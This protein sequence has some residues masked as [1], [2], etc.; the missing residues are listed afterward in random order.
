MSKAPGEQ[1]LQTVLAVVL[2][3]DCS[4]SVRLLHSN[5]APGA[6]QKELESHQELLPIEAHLKQ[7]PYFGSRGFLGLRAGF[8]LLQ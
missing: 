2:L 3:D 6:I 1:G 8:E 5:S 7:R 4:G